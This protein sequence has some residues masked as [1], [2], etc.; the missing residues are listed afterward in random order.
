MAPVPKQGNIPLGVGN[1]RGVLCGAVGSKAVAKVSRRHLC[2]VLARCTE[3]QFGA[4]RGLGTDMASMYVRCFWNDLRACSCAGAV[5]YC[6]LVAAFYSAVTQHVL[7]DFLPSDVVPMV[8][9]A[10]KLEG[11]ALQE[12]EDGVAN[13]VLQNDP[14]Y[15]ARWI[16]LIQDWV[17]LPYFKVRDDPRCVQTHLGTRPGD[18]LADILFSLVF[19]CFEKSLREKLDRLGLVP[20][21]PVASDS[22]LEPTVFDSE[23]PIPGPAYLDDMAIC[24]K[25]P[26]DELLDD[27]AEVVDI[28]MRTA[29]VYGFQMNLKPGKTEIMMNI[30]GVGASHAVHVLSKCPKADDGVVVHVVRASDAAEG[31]EDVPPR[32]SGP[33][34]VLDG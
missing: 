19:Y 23:V 4:Q 32:P 15:D 29:R 9:Q 21:Y 27:V 2:D 8:M 28:T 17:R 3:N 7:G 14:L 18:P 1:A 34:E 24:I 11:E 25:A 22:L 10:L 13:P 20:S 6:D 16:P 30:C 12:F 5:L 33:A 31:H 26:C